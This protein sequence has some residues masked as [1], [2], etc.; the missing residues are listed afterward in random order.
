[1]FVLDDFNTTSL[2]L[3]SQSG[4]ILAIR[5][6]LGN[7][8]SLDFV[9]ANLSLRFSLKVFGGQLYRL[10]I[11]RLQFSCFLGGQVN[12]L[13]AESRRDTGGA[14]SAIKGFIDSIDNIAC[15]KIFAR[16]NLVCPRQHIISHSFG[17][18]LS[19]GDKS[20][21]V[22][23]H[24]LNSVVL[25]SRNNQLTSFRQSKRLCSFRLLLH[26]V[27]DFFIGSGVIIRD[28][29]VG[30]IGEPFSVLTPNSIL[31]QMLFE[32]F[33][34]QRLINRPI[35]LG[36]NSIDVAVLLCEGGLHTDVVTE[37]LNDTT[38]ITQDGF[39]ELLCGHIEQLG[40]ILRS[41]SVLDGV[42]ST[43]SFIGIELGI[44]LDVGLLGSPGIRSIQLVVC[45]HI[46]VDGLLVKQ[47]ANISKLG[48]T[49][50]RDSNR[51]HSETIAFQ[52]IQQF[53]R[54]DVMHSNQVF[55]LLNGITKR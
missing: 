17:C 8:H 25:N 28:D 43:N 12:A 30:H 44:L 19:I 2:Q 1:M 29:G 31:I 36:R 55:R 51:R 42:N 54:S 24:I 50:V 13:L 47:Y 45:I 33:V 46:R 48:E 7:N 26:L 3:A 18:G 22:S 35:L 32:L 9:D 34:Q 14:V 49:L 15:G 41:D 23:P 4:E 11:Q 53:S 10:L 6:L 52:R 5:I 40:S 16:G 20:T 27:D 21:F 37:G 38:I 39:L